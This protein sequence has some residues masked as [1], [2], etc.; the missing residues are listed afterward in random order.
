MFV[1]VGRF[2]VLRTKWAELMDEEESEPLD[3]E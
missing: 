3:D 1:V 2:Y